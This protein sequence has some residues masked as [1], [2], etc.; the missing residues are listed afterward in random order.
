[1]KRRLTECSNPQSSEAHRTVVIACGITLAVFT[2]SWS[3]CY[4]KCQDRASGVSTKKWYVEQNSMYIWCVNDG[5]SSMT[6]RGVNCIVNLKKWPINYKKALHKIF[7]K[8][9]RNSCVKQKNVLSFIYVLFVK[10]NCCQWVCC[11][12]I[13]TARL[14]YRNVHLTFVKS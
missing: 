1:M 7:E 6:R 8:I 9:L 12:N 13:I 11:R 4:Y 2:C 14:T 5:G 10:S 3:Y